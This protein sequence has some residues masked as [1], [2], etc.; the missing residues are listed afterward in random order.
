MMITNLPFTALRAFEVVVRL[1][2]FARAAEELGI[3]QSAVS[4]HV[5]TLEDW[6]G[7]RLLVR[8]ARATYPNEEGQMLAH[9]V[10][11]GLGRISDICLKLRSRN[12][13]EAAISVSCLPGFAINWLF[14]RLIRFDQQHPDVTVSIA[15]TPRPVTFSSGEADVAIRYGMGRYPGLYVRKLLGETLFP[16]CSPALLEGDPPLRTMA[17]LAGHTLLVDDLAPVGG[18]PP[19]WEF[20]ARESGVTLPRPARVRR[21]GQSNMVIQAAI[22]G[23]GVALGRDAL[24]MD[25]LAEGRLCRPFAGEVQSDYAFW[26][27]CPEGALENAWIR[28]FHDWLFSEAEAGD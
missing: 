2:G 20:W 7:Q 18:R 11:E 10:A 26:F 13:R 15:T 5:R 16:V 27:V 14:P 3:S 28:A 12:P 23:L 4:Q 17:D 24:V 19:T 21:F 1:H 25:A 6:M 22:G 8:G 9:A